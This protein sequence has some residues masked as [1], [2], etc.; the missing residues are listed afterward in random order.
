L[1]GPDGRGGTGFAASDSRKQLPIYV[2]IASE[3]E[4]VKAVMAKELMGDRSLADAVQFVRLMTPGV[5]HTKNLK[6]HN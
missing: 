1:S 4:E 5:Y 3:D 6:Q 2:Y